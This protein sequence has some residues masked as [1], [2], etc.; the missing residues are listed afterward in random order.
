MWDVRDDGR[1]SAE[2]HMAVDQRALESLSEK[3]PPHLR[4]FEW[5]EPSVTFGYLLDETAVQEWASGFG[6][7]LIVKRPTGGGAVVHQPSD[8]AL[9]IL[10]PRGSGI[11]PDRPQKA[12]VAI[13]SIILGVLKNHLSKTFYLQQNCR[14]TPHINRFSACFSEPVCND[15]MEDGKKIVGGAL[16]ITRSAVLYQGDIHLSEGTD[17]KKLKTLLS[18]EFKK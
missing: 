4:L 13:H 10:W 1:R 15:V 18:E 3:S 9:S 6:K 12:Y 2:D 17:K 5:A 14:A 11:L 8:L 16:R 7:F